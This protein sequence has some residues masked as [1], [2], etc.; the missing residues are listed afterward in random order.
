M[1]PI[2]FL[3]HFRFFGYAIFD[4]AA[5]FLG[6]WLLSPWLSKL[7][8]KFHLDVPRE[9]WLF[10]TLPISILAHLLV[11]RNTPLTGDF[12]N[13][14]DHYLVK[15]LIFSLFFLG[16]RDIKKIKKNP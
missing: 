12:I 1:I 8:L 7:F 10:L 2:D 15:I 13:L 11:G 9:N 16:T 14:Q 5:T 3:R 6:I 4:L